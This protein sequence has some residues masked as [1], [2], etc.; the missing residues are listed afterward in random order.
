MCFL[1]ERGVVRSGEE[2]TCILWR[3]R[4]GGMFSGLRRIRTT[5]RRG[6][7]TCITRAFD[8]WLLNL[9]HYHGMHLAL[10]IVV[11]GMC[12]YF[13]HHTKNMFL[14]F[15]CRCWDVIFQKG[16]ISYKIWLFI[17]RS[18][19]IFPDQG[20]QCTLTGKVGHLKISNL[21]QKCFSFSE[22]KSQLI[23]TVLS[24]SFPDE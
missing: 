10:E 7:Y 12:S 11:I 14:N 5:R 2:S 4:G 22:K 6:L 24:D 13:G 17:G 20:C 8:I 9:W 16:K 21:Q 18:C 19:N 3:M 15:C 1:V 23:M